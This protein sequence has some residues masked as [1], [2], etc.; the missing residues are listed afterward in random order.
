[1]GKQKIKGGLGFRDLDSFNSALL[2]K[3]AW[4]F[5]QNPFSLAATIFREKY[6]NAKYLLEAKLGSNPSL[7]WRSIWGSL[8]LLKEGL[9]WRVGNGK[10]IEVWGHKWLNSPSTFK[11]QSPV[12]VLEQEARVCELLDQSGF[13]WN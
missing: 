8:K 12:R 10:S 11:V 9:R 7:I 4:R 13:S 5:L 6:F 2:A 1:M 3:Q